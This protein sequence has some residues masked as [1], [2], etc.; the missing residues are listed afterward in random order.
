MS[1]SHHL[2]SMQLSDPEELLKKYKQ[3]VSVSLISLAKQFANP[4]RSDEKKETKEESDVS[5]LAQYSAFSRFKVRLTNKFTQQEQHEFLQWINELEKPSAVLTSFEYVILGLAY[6]YGLGCNQNSQKA[7]ELFNQVKNENNYAMVLLGW[8]HE[9]GI[10]TTTDLGKAFICYE[11]VINKE[12]LGLAYHFLAR[13]YEKRNYLETSGELALEHYQLGANRGE[14][15]AI[16]NLGWCYVDETGVAKDLNKAIRYWVDSIQQGCLSALISYATHV[17]SLYDPKQQFAFYMIGVEQGNDTAFYHAGICYEEGRGVI[18]DIAI[19]AKYYWQAHVLGNRDAAWRL[20]DLR[21]VDKNNDVVMYYFD[22]LQV[23][24]KH[25]NTLLGE[26]GKLF[27]RLILDDFSSEF[28]KVVKQAI[29]VAL[30]LLPPNGKTQEMTGLCRLRANLAIHFF[31]Q[32]DVGRACFYLR[33]LH[34]SSFNGESL[35]AEENFQL[36]Y[37]LFTYAKNFSYELSSG[38]NPWTDRVY[39]ST[40]SHQDAQYEEQFVLSQARFFLNQ[41][42]KQNHTAAKGFLNQISAPSLML[43]SGLSFVENRYVIP[44]TNSQDVQE[45]KKTENEQKGSF[46][47]S[48]QK[49]VVKHGFS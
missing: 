46:D 14:I 3:A 44:K 10:G 11:S 40:F 4:H 39:R 22:F 49:Q 12:G 32:Q 25:L 8:L 26:S 29:K 24:Y 33:D 16:T 37:W 47:E 2:K 6:Q 5:T 48:E 30:V 9:N 38:L 17:L 23:D 35:S 45:E 19:A 18:K 7:F 34:Q 36:G 31:N 13:I 20:E 41:A 42:A 15:A 21:H 43:G 28:P 27:S 1:Q